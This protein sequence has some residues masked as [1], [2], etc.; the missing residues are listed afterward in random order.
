MPW[1]ICKQQHN[2]PQ[3]ATTCHNVP[4]QQLCLITTSRLGK[5]WTE[6]IK[7]PLEPTE[8]PFFFCCFLW[9]FHAIFRPSA[10]IQP[11]PSRLQVAAR[12]SIPPWR[13]RWVHL[14]LSST[15]TPRIHHTSTPGRRAPSG[16]CQ[17]SPELPG[18]VN[19]Q[20]TMERSTIFNG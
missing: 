12:G 6:I 18:L 10:I 15:N 3:R 19:I 2:V 9:V 4:F 8:K 14:Q 1:A 17:I 5:T 11:Q 20:K 13:Y 7:R 16:N